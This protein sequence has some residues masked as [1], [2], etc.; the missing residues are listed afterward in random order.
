MPN[1]MERIWSSS[2]MLSVEYIHNWV[3]MDPTY[4]HLAMYLMISV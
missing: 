4:D 1:D 2:G 3:Q